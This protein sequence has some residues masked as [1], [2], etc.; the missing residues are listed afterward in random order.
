MQRTDWAVA[1]GDRVGRLIDP[2]SQAEQS[3]GPVAS[4]STM[5]LI[6]GAPSAGDGVAM[7][8]LSPEFQRR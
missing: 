4:D 8:F 5:F 3:I 6:K 2:R 1:V 7:T